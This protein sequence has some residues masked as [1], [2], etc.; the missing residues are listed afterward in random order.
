[1]RTAPD[2]NGFFVGDYE[3]LTATPRSFTSV[4]G[5]ANTN[6][7]NNRTD[8]FATSFRSMFDPFGDVARAAAARNANR[9][10]ITRFVRQADAINGA[11]RLR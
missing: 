4:F 9:L 1:M 10:P 5:A 8:I 6:D 11:I 3:G 7:L 2:A